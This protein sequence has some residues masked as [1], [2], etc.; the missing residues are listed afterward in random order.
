M[1]LVLDIGGTSLKFKVFNLQRKPIFSNTIHYHKIINN[2]EILSIVDKLYTTLKQKYPI[3]KIAISSLGIVDNKTGKISGLG[4]INNYN[5][6]NWKTFFAKRHIPVFI[7]NDANCAALYELSLNPSIDNAIVL[8][9][10]TG[11]G[12]ATIIG[13]K[14]YKGSHGGAGEVGIGVSELKNKK[15]YNISTAT[16]TYAITSRYFNQTS[17]KL[18]GKDIITLYGKSKIATKIIDEVVFNLSK[19]IINHALFLD[20]K[21]VFIGGAISANKTYMKLLT[22]K[23]DHLMKLSGQTKSFKLEKCHDSN[24][25]NINGA[26]TLI[27]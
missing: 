15:F 25:A 17:K 10:G 5:N 9:V 7:E 12:G 3:T 21:Y 16:S 27:K 13:G 6:V 4:G 19:V 1:Y 24:D 8:V 14:L 20:V 2:K 11:L 22:K 23:V 26:L 18:N